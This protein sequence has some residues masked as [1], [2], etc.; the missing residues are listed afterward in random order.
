VS[1]RKGRRGPG[2]SA[3]GWVVG[4]VGD[5]LSIMINETHNE[6]CHGNFP[7]LVN[8]EN[9]AIRP[10]VMCAETEDSAFQHDL[11]ICKRSAR[12]CPSVGLGVNEGFG[13][14]NALKIA[15]VAVTLDE[16]VVEDSVDECP[17]CSVVYAQ[18]AIIR[19]Q[20]VVV[21]TVVIIII[22]GSPAMWDSDPF[23]LHLVPVPFI[24]RHAY[25][26]W[27]TCDA[28]QRHHRQR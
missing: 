28:S 25:H 27:F 22:Y 12:L 9:S 15:R 19:V 11:S 8:A 14:P 17:P 5:A 2:W 13:D 7:R 3:I 26:F 10:G 18:C 16:A 1:G 21:A 4:G 23:G 6:C 24:C 20:S